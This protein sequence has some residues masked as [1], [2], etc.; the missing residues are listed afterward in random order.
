MYATLTYEYSISNYQLIST[1]WWSWHSAKI[2]IFQSLTT[3]RQHKEQQ[4]F[5]WIWYVQRMQKAIC[6]PL[7]ITLGDPKIISRQSWN[8]ST[9]N[10]LIHIP[11]C[12]QK[13]WQFTITLS[14]T[15]VS[16]K[17]QQHFQA[18][19]LKCTHCFG[20]QSVWWHQSIVWLQFGS[21]QLSKAYETL[22]TN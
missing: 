6:Q 19:D 9:N 20:H 15:V 22:A 16:R 5:T 7:W 18:P 8:N 21:K 1:P 12:Y 13:R 2:D 17:T 11:S 14:F 3:R 10:C 4:V